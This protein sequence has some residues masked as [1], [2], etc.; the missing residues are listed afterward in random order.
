MSR[1]KFL[2]NIKQKENPWAQKSY[3]EAK[4]EVEEFIQKNQDGHSV[5]SRYKYRANEHD[6]E[7]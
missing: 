5:F 7:R 6:D 2:K 4:K 3:E 1:F